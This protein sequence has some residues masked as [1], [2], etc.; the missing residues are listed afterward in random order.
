MPFV[1]LGSLITHHNLESS[2]YVSE[3]MLK[4]LNK[5]IGGM[6][7]NGLHRFYTTYSEFM[8]QIPKEIG[9]NGD[10]DGKAMKV[11]Q[12]RR[13]LKLFLYLIALALVIFIVEMVTF[14]ARMLYN[15]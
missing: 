13:V 6:M 9:K 11:I 15:N 10:D 5:A 7:E 12:L 14:Y 8:L 2:H 4:H 3:Q 1:N